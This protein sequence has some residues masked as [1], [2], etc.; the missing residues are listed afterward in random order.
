[1]QNYTE[2]EELATRAYLD[3][4]EL[5]ESD[6]AKQDQK[7]VEDTEVLLREDLRQII[8]DKKSID[9]VQVLVDQINVNLDR[10]EKLLS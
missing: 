7:L 2:A 6:L 3:N 10:A 8:K 1:M 4:F 9:E 5:V